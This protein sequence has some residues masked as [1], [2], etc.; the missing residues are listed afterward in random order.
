[1]RWAARAWLTGCAANSQAITK[2]TGTAIRKARWT[3]VW[4]RVEN[5]IEVAQSQSPNG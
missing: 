4:S 2:K 1:M 5:S 3:A